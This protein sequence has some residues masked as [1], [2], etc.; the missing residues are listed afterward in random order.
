MGFDLVAGDDLYAEAAGSPGEEPSS[1][2]ERSDAPDG[3]RELGLGE[4]GAAAKGEGADF[5]SVDT[6]NGRGPLGPA[7][8][9]E[10][11][12]P[13]AFGSGTNFK[14]VMKSAW[15]LGEVMR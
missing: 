8:D 11:H 5:E 13:D 12:G 14:S 10:E 4:A 7:L 9:I 15:G 6:G 1:L 2:I 3:G